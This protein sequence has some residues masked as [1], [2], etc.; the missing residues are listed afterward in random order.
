M[1]DVTGPDR[2]AGHPRAGNGRRLC[3]P[4]GYVVP[5]AFAAHEHLRAGRVYAIAALSRD[6][7]VSV[8]MTTDGKGMGCGEDYTS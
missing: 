4:R 5:I 6:L 3:S 7:T 2:S 8:R 1:F